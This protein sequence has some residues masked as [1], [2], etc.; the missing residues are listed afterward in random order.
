MC[1]MCVPIGDVG[2]LCI[3]ICLCARAC[4]SALGPSLSSFSPW[5]TSDGR[6]L[7]PHLFPIQ[8]HP[9]LGT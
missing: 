3:C 2:L 4:G 6:F 1:V 5:T 7:F 8:P 9:S